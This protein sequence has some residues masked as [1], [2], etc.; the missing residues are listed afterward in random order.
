MSFYQILKKDYQN[1]RL[2]HSNKFGIFDVIYLPSFKIV[3]IFR[4]SQFC[5]KYIIL[6]PIAYF[7]TFMNDFL[8]GVWIGPSVKVGEGFFLGH[9][10]GL[11]ANPDFKYSV[12]G[13]PNYS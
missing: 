8:H 9:P 10:R 2:V 12:N 7:F 4:L 3:F 13:P 11:V 5:S 6:K 1:F